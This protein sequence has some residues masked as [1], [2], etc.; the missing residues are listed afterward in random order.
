VGSCGA[1]FDVNFSVKWFEVVDG[2]RHMMEVSQLLD[3]IISVV[4][5]SAT[6]LLFSVT[7][8]RVYSVFFRNT[9]LF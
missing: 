8:N 7:A 6:S 1:S 4:L 5:G 9:E 3:V 2:E